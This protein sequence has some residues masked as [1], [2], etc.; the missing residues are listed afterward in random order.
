MNERGKEG[1]LEIRMILNQKVDRSS[2]RSVKRTKDENKA[3]KND[4]REL[5][6]GRNAE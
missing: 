5:L 2:R 4:R 1:L 6:K 3:A